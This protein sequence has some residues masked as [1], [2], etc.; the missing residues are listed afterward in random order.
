LGITASV[1]D[2][3]KRPLPPTYFLASICVILGLHFLLPV[4]EVLPLPWR[5]G[6]LIFIAVGVWLNVA[7]DQ[8]LKVHKTTV[9][10]FERSRVLVTEGAFRFSRNPMYLGMVLILFGGA[11]SLGSLSPFLVC[12]AFAALLHFRFILVEERMLAETFGPQWEAYRNRTR[13]WI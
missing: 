3:S 5:L 4:A 8:A 10:P 2:T 7:A 11:M 12:P 9:K 6:G 1:P 13:R